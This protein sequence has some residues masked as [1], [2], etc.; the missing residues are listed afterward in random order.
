MNIIFMGKHTTDLYL[1]PWCNHFVFL[2]LKQCKHTEGYKQSYN[3]LGYDAHPKGNN[4]A[5]A[6][7]KARMANFKYESNVQG[8]LPNYTNFTWAFGLAYIGLL[9]AN[10]QILYH[11]HACKLLHKCPNIVHVRISK[12]WTMGIF[13]H[14]RVYSWLV[15]SW[16]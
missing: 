10:K 9:K 4:Q 6:K 14:H 11:I 1:G 2:Q 3:F 5:F 16:Q 7:W 15:H 13:K 12:D 8:T